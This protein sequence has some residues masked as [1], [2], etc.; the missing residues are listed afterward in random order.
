MIFNAPASISSED[1]S[2][3]QARTAPPAG[4]GLSMDVVVAPLV[5][6]F[7]FS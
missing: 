4:R 2:S 6:K 1:G 5:A 7:S 3:M